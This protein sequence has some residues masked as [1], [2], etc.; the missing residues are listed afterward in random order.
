MIAFVLCSKIL[1]LKLDAC[2][3]DMARFDFSTGRLPR[4]VSTRGDAIYKDDQV[5]GKYLSVC[6]LSL[7]FISVPSAFTASGSAG[8]CGGRRLNQ[9]TLVLEVMFESLPTNGILYPIFSPAAYAES[10]VLQYH[11]IE[12]L[13][14]FLVMNVTL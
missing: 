4:R 1:K 8:T 11:C 3:G 5:L 14:L 13:F 7:M 2:V 6:P 10:E 12:G 9:Y